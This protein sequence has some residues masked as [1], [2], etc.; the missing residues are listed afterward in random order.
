MLVA[1]KVVQV[2]SIYTHEDIRKCLPTIP[3]ISY[4]IKARC[5][6]EVVAPHHV[7]GKER[8]ENKHR[9]FLHF[10]ICFLLFFLVIAVTDDCVKF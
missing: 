9:C 8:I 6:K 10:D 3:T 2:A 1:I 5:V 4:T 7:P